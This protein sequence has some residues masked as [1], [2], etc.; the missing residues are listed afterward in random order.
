MSKIV[1]VSNSNYKVQVATGGT[2]TFDT[3]NDSSPEVYGE[4]LIKGNLIVSGTQTSIETI[5]SQINDNI[6][7]L[8]AG[9]SSVGISAINNYQAGIEIDR[10]PWNPVPGDPGRPPAQIIFDES[11]SHYDPATLSS[12]P[13]TFVVKTK[14]NLLSSIQLSSIGTQ[15]GFDINFDLNN[16]ANVLAIARSTDTLSGDQY[17]ERVSDDNHIPN[18][19]FVTEYVSSGTYITGM[20]DV[21]K[22]YVADTSV[23]AFDSSVNATKITT[24]TGATIAAGNPGVLSF[25]ATTGDNLMPGMLLQGGGVTADTYLVSKTGADWTLN[26]AASGFP[27]TA[28]YTEPFS[29]ADPTP[30][31]IQSQVI[32]TVDGVIQSQLTNTGFYINNIK[33]KDNTIK[34]FSVGSNLVL[35]ANSDIVESNAVL[36]LD[37]KTAPSYTTGGTRI[38]SNTPEAGKTGIFYVNNVNYQDELVAKNRALLFSMIF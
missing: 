8:N 16:T 12:I 38:Y 31:A 33:I 7:I 21:D 10:G 15:A 11:V 26:Q 34:N 18:R 3:T 35:T 32:F 37:N 27:T 29:P 28:I 24:I 22:L 4:V 36:Q 23:R 19:R 14:D 30:L 13:G 5:D 1:K 17:W 6:I 20:A 2:I 25:T 9:E